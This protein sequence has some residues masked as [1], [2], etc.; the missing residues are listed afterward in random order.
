MGVWTEERG[1][2][3][4][5]SYFAGHEGP[6]YTPGVAYRIVQKMLGRIPSLSATGNF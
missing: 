3:F 1:L 6:W 2:T 4:Y 5:V